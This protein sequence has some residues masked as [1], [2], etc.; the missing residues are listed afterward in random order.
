MSDLQKLQT[1]LKLRGFSPLTVRNY[2]FFV[3]KFLKHAD[4][5]SPELTEAD[6]KNYLSTLFEDKSKNTIMLAA[7]SI[8][9]FFQ[10]ILKKD[11]SN[12]K[13]PKK[14]KYLPDVLTKDEVRLLIENAET[15]KSKLIISVL[16]SSGLRVSEVVGLRPE[17]IDF[18][19]NV[20][21]VRKGKGNK[22]RTFT[23]SIKL[24]KQIQDY[25]KKH[26]ENKYLFSKDKPLTTRNIQKIIK[27]LK[28]KT[29][30]NKRVT[31]HTLRHSFATHL[32][33]S[34]TDIRMIQTL[35][36]HSS[37]NTTQIYTHISTEQIKKVK[38]PFDGL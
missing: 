26:D 2:S 25:L 38:N 21:K 14:D 29:G 34:G 7:A 18:N 6:V 22:D 35:L 15:K 9:F 20:G 3:D 4:K 12:V 16:Y 24:S 32:L 10:E 17:D 37:L 31:P 30:I 1:E 27:N 33:E 19:E 11:M 28:E 13:I 5:S 23:I 36:G 8:K